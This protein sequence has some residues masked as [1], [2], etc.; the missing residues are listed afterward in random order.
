MAGGLTALGVAIRLTKS[1]GLTS[2]FEKVEFLE[3]AKTTCVGM[4]GDTFALGLLENGVS[5]KT[6]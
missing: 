3:F 5:R 4:R 2:H 6:R 1:G